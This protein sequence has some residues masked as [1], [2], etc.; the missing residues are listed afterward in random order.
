MPDRFDI[1]AGHLECHSC[2][3]QN[4]TG[5]RLPITTSVLGAMRYILSCDSKALFRFEAAASTLEQLAQVTEAY[6][7]TQL[8]RGFSTLD[9]YKSLF[10]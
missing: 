2:R 4:S 3:D 5:L 8:E 1:A 10:I 7:T 6:L 9:F